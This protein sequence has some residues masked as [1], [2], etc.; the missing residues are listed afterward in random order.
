ME[1]IVTAAMTL[2][3]GAVA[4]VAWR[5]ALYSRSPKVILLALGFALFFLKG[6]VLSIALFWAGAWGADFLMTMV[7]IDLGILLL[8]YLA[9]LRRSGP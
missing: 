3:A 1:S 2:T 7:L 8:F 4:V 5:A 6:L 9:I